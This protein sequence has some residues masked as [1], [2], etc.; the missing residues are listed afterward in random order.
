MNV[1]SLADAIRVL[2]LFCG[3]FWVSSGNICIFAARAAQ[4][5]DLPKNATIVVGERPLAGSFSLPQQRGSRMFLPVV[6]ISR[7]LGD[8]VTVDSASRS[9]EVHRQTGL[10]ASFDAR[11]NQVREN[12]AIVMVV[13]DTA[14]IIF[15]PS[16][17]ELML[18]IEILA[19]LLDVSIIS[20]KT[21][22]I[23]K[24]TRGPVTADAVRSG[25][26]HAPWELYQVDYS[27]NLNQYSSA[28][29]HNLN[30]H[31]SGR[32]GDGRFDLLSNFD[33]GTARGP[34]IFRR[35]TFTFERENGQRLI[36]GDFGTGTDLEFLS[37]A[38]R[39]VSIQQPFDDLRVTLFGGRAISDVFPIIS[40]TDPLTGLPLEP[41]LQPKPQYDI[42]VFGAFATFGP[43]A[44]KPV[45]SRFLSFS[46][47]LMY[48]GGPMNSGEL[49]TAS[50]RY[51]S[52]RNQFQ[53]DVGIGDFSGIT[54]SKR[55]VRGFA[56]VVD[57]SELFSVTDGFTVRA[58]YSHIGLNYLSPQAGGLFTPMNLVSGGFNWRVKSWLSTSLSGTSRTLLDPPGQTTA[59]SNPGGELS[60]T[61]RSITATLSVTPRGIW[62][63]FIFTHTQGINSLS[64]TNAYTLLNA[65]KE[66]SGWRVFGNFTRI[67]NAQFLN[68]GIT[69]TPVLTPPSEN[70]TFGVMTKLGATNTLQ[71]SQSFGSAGSVGGEAD[72]TAASF[73]SKRLTFGAGLGYA[74]SHSQLSLVE[75]ALATVQL[76]FQQTLQV[77]YINTP[78]GPQI[79]LQLRGSFLRSRR[80]EAVQN[81]AIADMR[82]FGALSGKVYQD[83]NLNGRFDPGVD[84]PLEGVQ[85]RVDGSYYEVSDRNGDFRVENIK[86]GEH[87]VYLDLLSVRADLTLITS[88]QQTVALR[89]G[90]DM[91]VDFRLVRT[92]RVRGIVWADLNGNG[93]IDEGEPTLA[94]VRVVTGSGRDTL[95]DTQG[96]FI[97]GDLPPGEHVVL[98]DEKTLPEGTKSA[99][100]SLRV[101]IEAG[102]E[103]NNA[104]FPIVPKP[105]EVTV[106]HFPSSDQKP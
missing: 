65:T 2:A 86:A 35:N 47:G 33:G 105:A 31:A 75:R 91:I 67:Q 93:K 56:P 27:A 96:E 30:V 82:N 14:D 103:T 21:S 46:T 84:K 54:Q 20:D 48:F 87:L 16:P 79:A 23:V 64:G 25:E 42:N 36:G 6:S 15:P 104:N 34:L 98:I 89:S 38:V 22:G 95:T 4:I 13:S 62:P 80:A 39:G 85:V 57:L 10:V 72:W 28:F 11:Q 99:I 100:G 3:L 5:T 66:F 41:T 51:N 18:P 26:E 69:N 88:P 74:M 24:I 61:D 1:R 94:D 60:Q 49:A 9:V 12:G 53:G 8:S 97:L 40:K 55:D 58:R 92:G 45:D 19:P 59:V 50:I 101:N 77:A 44:K 63:T 81:A 90:R 17:D 71:V 29:N 102:G 76:P 32:I 73:L 106:K 52:Q 78:T 37:S 83:I 68:L 43:S 7:A 70:V